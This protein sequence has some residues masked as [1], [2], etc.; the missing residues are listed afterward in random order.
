MKAK[1][2]PS[3]S[4]G[5]NVMKKEIPKVRFT[6]AKN[7]YRLNSKALLKPSLKI[8][9]LI[10]IDSDTPVTPPQRENGQISH[11]TRGSSVLAR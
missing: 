2:V 3:K 10:D 9:T 4:T 5:K 11:S 8:T 1:V 7:K 6:W